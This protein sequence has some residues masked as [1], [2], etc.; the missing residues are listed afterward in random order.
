MKYET[1]YRIRKHSIID[2]MSIANF[3]DVNCVSIFFSK[4]L[5]LVS[6]KFDFYLNHFLSW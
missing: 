4:S 1:K 6:V 3:N 5:H 2:K